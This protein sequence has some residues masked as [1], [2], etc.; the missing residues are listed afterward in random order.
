MKMGKAK[1]RCSMYRTCKRYVCRHITPH[2][3]YNTDK[4][5]ENCERMYCG[6]IGLHVACKPVKGTP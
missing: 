5:G 1:V 6:H 4:D 3:K 2:V